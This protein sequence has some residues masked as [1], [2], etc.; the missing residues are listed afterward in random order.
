MGAHVHGHAVV[1][2]VSSISFPIR[3][4]N[5]PARQLFDLAS[6]SRPCVRSRDNRMDYPLFGSRTSIYGLCIDFFVVRT[7]MSC[8]MTYSRD[9]KRRVPSLFR[10]HL[11]SRIRELREAQGLRQREVADL[12]GLRP[13]R[14]NK[15]ES[16]QQPPPTFAL[17]KLA[18]ALGRPVD[19]FLPELKLQPEEDR[20]FY[21]QVR[22][23]WGYSP[24]LRR[25]I[26][27]LIRAVCDCMDHYETGRPAQPVKEAS[28][29]PR[30]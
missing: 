6:K 5:L 9:P 17:Y 26:G 25:G 14:L 11:A 3:V 21:Q 7:A 28:R 18:L 2:L 12:A 24:E 30:F 27:M 20:I 13:D 4:P 29:A 15:Y 22:R 10:A 1:V 16:G 8:S 23:V 19:L